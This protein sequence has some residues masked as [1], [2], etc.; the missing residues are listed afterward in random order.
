M[1]IKSVRR[2][3]MRTMHLIP[4]TDSRE[5]D[6][7]RERISFYICPRYYTGEAGIFRNSP[8]TTILS[9]PPPPPSPPRHPSPFHTV[10]RD[11]PVP[12][13]SFVWRGGKG[14]GEGLYVPPSLCVSQKAKTPDENQAEREREREM[15]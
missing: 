12:F 11:H 10:R 5:E 3:A 13:V 9:Y 4:V 1:G 2:L 14:G 7:K 15:K 6:S 8:Q